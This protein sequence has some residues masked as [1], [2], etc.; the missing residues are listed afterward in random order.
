MGERKYKVNWGEAIVP[1]IA[2]AFGMA[3]F[4]Q[5]RDAPPA[6]MYWPVIAAVLTGILGILIIF[7]FVVGT[8]REAVAVAPKG[9]A[10]KMREAKKPGVVFLC[11]TAYLAALPYVGFSI[12]N[13]LFMLAVFRG[14]GGRKWVLNIFVALGLTIFLHLILIVLMKM[15][16]PRLDIGWLMI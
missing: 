1:G 9:M 4:L 12:C 16:M 8:T 2:L 5:T 7:R 11:S 15:N 10:A 6:V 14:L 3:F 13:I